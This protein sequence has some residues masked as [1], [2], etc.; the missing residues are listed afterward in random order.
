[1][2]KG[3]PCPHGAAKCTNCG[4][5]H[6]ARA[7]ACAARREARTL[8]TSLVQGTMLYGVE[9]TWNAKRGVEGEYQRAINRMARSTLGAFRSTP[10]GIL[11][12]ESGR[13]PARLL[14]DFR[15]V[16][17]SHR[18]LAAIRRALSDA[19]GP[20]EQW[21]KAII[22][23]ASRLIE[24]SNEVLILWVPAHAGVTGNEAADGMA[25]EATAGQTH[26]VPDQVRWQASL[27]HLARRATERRS[28]ATALW[29]RDQV[30]PER[31]YVP[32]RGPGF[33]KRAMR[34]VRKST[35]QRYYQLL[36]SHTAIGSF[37]HDRMT[38]PQ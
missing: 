1:M 32:P 22:E 23:V 4:E 20:G 17:F 37:L 12:G 26:D 15:Q 21:A 13:T 14:L 35:A 29:I 25:K 5:A 30:R 18:L 11:V 38:G 33:R 9:L 3:H 31:C 10:Q 6:G 27:P 2:G 36:S 16:G 28:G 19:L 24:S 8:S 7:D 34:R